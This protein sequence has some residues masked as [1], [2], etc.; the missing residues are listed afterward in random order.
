MMTS[1]T[2]KQ[3]EIH[4][5]VLSTVAKDGLV[6]KRIAMSIRSA[7]FEEYYKMELPLNLLYKSHH[8]RQ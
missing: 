6:L 5:M 3:L 7:V 2:N 4:R 8:S 1:L